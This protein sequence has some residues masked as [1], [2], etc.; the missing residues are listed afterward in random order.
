MSSSNLK[1]LANRE[2]AQ[3]STGPRTPEGKQRSRLNAVRHGLTGQVVILAEEDMKR[4]HCLCKEFLE[5]WQPQGPTEKHLVQTLADQQ[6]RLHSAHARERGV[7]ALGF[8]KFGETIDTQN[9]E[10]HALLTAATVAL[11][12]GAELDRLS[13]YS[14][15]IQR[16]YH[17]ALK[18]IK[19]LQAERKARER[20]EMHDAS[21]IQQLM[22]M[23][24]IPWNP[25]D[26][27]FVSSTAQVNL[28]TRRSQHSRDAWI[29]TVAGFNKEKFVAAGGRLE[30]QS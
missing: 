8:D 10:V 25:S 5:E 11:E 16:D 12:Q 2:N 29:A 26:D 24:E 27:G 22:Q 4:Y 28:Y 19:T 20:D 15:R 7:Y 18:E 21:Q 9:P 13:R 1:I 3:K 30:N 6:W 17:N 23:Q 14:S